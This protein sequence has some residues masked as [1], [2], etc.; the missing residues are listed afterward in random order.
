[1]KRYGKAT[2]E[3]QQLVT[4]VR[5]EH[6]PDLGRV[7]LEVLAVESDAGIDPVSVAILGPAARAAGAADVAILIDR[8][9]WGEAANEDRAAW[10]DNALSG[11]RVVHR[12][13]L[14]V[15]DAAGRPVVRRRKPAYRLAVHAEA[16]ERHGKHAPGFEA[17][18]QVERA[19]R[20]G[21]RQTSTVG[22]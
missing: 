22:A 19:V 17:A 7:R 20:R 6:H 13:G 1:M 5:R 11:I 18:R 16:L 9:A 14:V 3:V 12:A 10:I 2:S 15:V 8:E 4:H 21:K